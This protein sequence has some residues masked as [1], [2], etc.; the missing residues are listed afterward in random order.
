LRPDR[1]ARARRFFPVALGAAAFLV[2]MSSW[3]FF[4]NDAPLPDPTAP[5]DPPAIAG[6]PPIPEPPASTPPLREGTTVAAAASD[7]GQPA[8]SLPA[9][10]A[11]ISGI[12]RDSEGGMPL[13]RFRVRVAKTQK[14]AIFL[15]WNAEAVERRFEG[16]LGAFTLGGLEGGTYALQFEAE[17]YVKDGL[18]GVVVGEAES[19]SGIEISL[20]RGATIRGLVVDAVTRS[21]VEGARISVDTIETSESL[22]PSMSSGDVATGKTG[23]FEL[24]GVRPG[25]ATLQV[26]SRGY[27]DPPGQRLD[28][29]PGRVVEGLLVELERGGAIEGFVFESDGSPVPRVSVHARRPYPLSPGGRSAVTGPDGAFRI[30][31]LAPARY[32]VTAELPAPEDEDPYTGAPR[33]LKAIAAVER[34]AT[35]RVEL[36]ARAPGGPTVRGRV[37]RAGEPVVRARVS[38]STRIPGEE[39]FPS[40]SSRRPNPSMTAEDG[41]YE[42]RDVPPGQATL[43]VIQLRHE[44]RRFSLTIPEAGELVFD[45][46]L[47]D[48]PAGVIAGRVV[49]ASDGSPLRGAS[50]SAHRV[51]GGSP[52]SGG[53]TATDEDGKYRIEGLSAGRYS[54]RVDPAPPAPEGQPLADE[55]GTEIR[56]PVVLAGA[57][58]V[59]V[60]FALGSAGRALVV[61]RDPSGRPVPKALVSLLPAGGAA[62]LDR[63][64]R[65]VP[66]EK[67]RGEY[68]LAG[69]PPGRYYAQVLSLESWETGWSEE[70]NIAAATESVFHVDIR[71]GTPVDVRLVVEDL[72]APSSRLVR[73]R[74][75]RKRTVATGTLFDVLLG[76]GTRR[77]LCR[78]LLPSGRWT[79][80][81]SVTGYREESIPVVVEEGV[82]QEV[83]VRLE[84]EESPR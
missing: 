61:V 28:L 80:F 30:Q 15:R 14:P 56:E 19:K 37:F 45:V 12:V 7:A 34:G 51:D 53:S 17:G 35:A 3:D 16:T 50:V 55:L 82:P 44:A 20:R 64:G 68:L 75:E 31:D 42:I 10:K 21:P 2:A 74:D 58:P 57:G 54:V 25:I 52:V 43:S 6:A 27:M 8:A 11:G 47:P 23:V 41:S 1:Q 65:Q 9:G 5:A 13:E 76:G 18:D 24:E 73:F 36:R 77:D 60:D 84:P 26:T 33:D 4:G 72:Q 83:T 32:L 66:F 81:V 59:A 71:R 78:T 22:M 63:A 39:E 46:H 38:L 69:V 67:D 62:G 79:L 48:L 49:R 40:S 70:R 29:Q